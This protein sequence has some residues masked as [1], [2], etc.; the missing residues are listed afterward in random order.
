MKRLASVAALLLI[1]AAG[2][3][4]QHSALDTVSSAK[5]P[6]A[7]AEAAPVVADHSGD[8]ETRVRRLEDNYAKYAEALDFLGKV[9]QQQKQQE[10]QQAREQ[11]DPKAVFAVNIDQNVK[12]GLFEGSNEAVVTI[13]EAFDFA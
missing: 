2:C 4:N 3:E 8:L 10:K 7:E 9:Y 11:H 12:M 6:K 1:T 13:V 5:S